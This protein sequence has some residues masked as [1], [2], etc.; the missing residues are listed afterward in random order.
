MY[1]FIKTNDKYTL[2]NTKIGVWGN[3]TKIKYA[4]VGSIVVCG[5]RYQVT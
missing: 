2:Y 4:L 5:F 1:D 3:I